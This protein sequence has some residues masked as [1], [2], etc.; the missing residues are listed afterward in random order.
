MTIVGVLFY[1]CAS[2]PSDRE[3]E[4]K[5]VLTAEVKPQQSEGYREGDAAMDFTLPNIDGQEYSLESLEDNKGV[6]L[7]FTCNHCPYAKAYEERIIALDKMYKEK[8]YPVVAINPN[9][10]EVQPEDSFEKMKERAAEKGFTFPYLL[11]EKQEVYP[12]YGATKTPHVFVLEKVEEEYVVRYVGAIDNNYS[13]AEQADKHY[14]QDAVDALL[15]GEEVPMTFT[16]A[17]GC[18][19]KVK[20]K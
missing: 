11:D 15:A 14:V 18:S 1:S 6:I 4:K 7:I 13:S 5:E 2:K 8:G 16:K 3:E 10:P 17:I 19:I 12:V 20:G 9:D